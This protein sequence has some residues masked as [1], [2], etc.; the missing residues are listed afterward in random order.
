MSGRI[1]VVGL[2]PA[3]PD[4]VTQG[5]LDRLAGAARVVLRTGR[6]PAAVVAAGAPTF[7]DVYD[8]E[9]SLAVVYRAIVEELAATA[10]GLGD[11]GDL[12][13]AVPGSPV[14]AERTVEL[15]VELALVTPGLELEV[16]PA[17]SFL[18]LAWVRLGV[19]PVARGVR[20]VDGQRFEVDAAGQP[21]PLLVAQCDS[22]HVLSDVKLALD[23]GDVP[24]LAPGETVTVLHHLGLDDE[25][26]VEIAWEDLDR[27][28]EPDHLTSLYLP[29]L[30]A[31]VGAEVQRFVELVDTLR[32]EC[33]WDRKQT[34]HSLRRHL[35]EESY[36]V[37]EAIDDLDV[38][39]GRGYEHLEEELGDLL[40]QVAFHSRLAGEE[41]QFTLADVAR[42]VHDKL[43][44]RHPHVFGD[45][46]VAGAD[47]VVANWEQIKKAEKGRDSVF[48]GIPAAM[49]A[50]LYA[51]KVQKKA[52]TLELG[53][54]DADV[55]G[56]SLGS[57]GTVD[58][59]G[60]DGLGD[61]LWDVVSR[62]RRLGLD[63]EDALRAATVRRLH[64]LR[65][66]ERSS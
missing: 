57:G 14:V 65:E 49:P 4:L 41:G 52:A 60:A 61:L 32:R 9:A 31:P 55:V 17:L 12:V 15:L 37:L 58:D 63:P 25:R 36:E 10:A 18:D 43:V 11:G 3:G 51:L 66:A 26:V 6:H 1:V 44:S 23:A 47:E 2:G 29:H 30:A 8:R 5:T 28:V 24:A 42:T 45:V 62:A 20:V 27:V 56:P 59:L 21:G 33:P 64:E 40:F 35:L 7:D 48:D 16:V 50:L 19:D 54:E 34:H 39:S 22:R 53:V 38:E 46:E 13:Y